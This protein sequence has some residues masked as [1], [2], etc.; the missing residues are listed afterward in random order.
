MRGVRMAD[1]MM[2]WR[3]VGTEQKEV[4]LRSLAPV[5]H[6]EII[7]I[8]YCSTHLT[9]LVKSR[10]RVGLGHPSLLGSSLAS[11]PTS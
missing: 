6:H 1:R 4:G 8:E 2:A 7:L 11:L 3:M 9:L 5:A 10:I